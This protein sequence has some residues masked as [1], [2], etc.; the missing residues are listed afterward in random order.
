MLTNI[1]PVENLRS[2]ARAKTKVFETKRLDPNL[3]PQ[4][5]DEGWEILK[6]SAKSVRLKRDK[7]LD[8]LL[9]DRVWSMF[10]QMDFPFMSGNGGGI[11]EIDPKSKENP[12]SQIDVVAI[13]DEVAIAIECKSA[14][15]PGKRLQFQE[16]LGKLS[17]L[18]KSF[19]DAINRYFPVPHKRKIVLAFFLQNIQLSEN[20]LARA[21]KANVLI[22]GD[23]EIEYYRKLTSHCQPPKLSTTH[24]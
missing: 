23:R 9:E 4:A 12:K 15:E 18:R 7:S 2:V 17:L 21:R 5:L 8:K 10:Y 14:H 13:D 6:K 19:H 24:K 1:E 22:F 20:D 3:V 16:D 11:L